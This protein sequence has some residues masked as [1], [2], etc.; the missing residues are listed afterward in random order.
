MMG[1]LIFE[2]VDGAREMRGV[3][4][5]GLGGNCRVGSRLHGWKGE[6]GE[7]KA[8]FA[9]GEFGR[10][11]AWFSSCLELVAGAFIRVLSV[12]LIMVLM[13]SISK[14]IWVLINDDYEF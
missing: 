3:G 5:G 14:Y 10:T 1:G 2:T 9:A 8:I 7:E 12:L 6:W 13:R 11:T 4:V